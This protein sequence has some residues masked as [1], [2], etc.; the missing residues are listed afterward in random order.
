MGKDGHV[1]G[2]KLADGRV[3]ACDDVV[4]GI[5]IVPNDEL[6]R[7]AGLECVDGIVVG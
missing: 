2:V 6:A 5:G 1:T 4:I 3:I 7:D